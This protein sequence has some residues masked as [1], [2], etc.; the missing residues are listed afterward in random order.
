[1][2]KTPV[3][4][5]GAGIGGLAA[6]LSLLRRGFP[7]RVFEK[8]STLRE[9]GAGFHCTPNGVRVLQALGLGPAIES[10]AVPLE[11]RDIRLWNSEIGRAH[12]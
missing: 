4:I 10:V 8:V 5:I 3:T 11:D 7:V 1:M 6:A 2:A 12:V 9:V